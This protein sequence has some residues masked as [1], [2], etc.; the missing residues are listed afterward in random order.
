M[1]VGMPSHLCSSSYGDNVPV[2]ATGRFVAVVTMLSGIIILALPITVIGTNFAR[3]LRKMQRD[4]MLSDLENLDHN[5][6]GVIDMSELEV[7]L[8]M[9]V[10][11]S[12]GWV[13]T[14]LR[15]CALVTVAPETA[16]SVGTDGRYGQLDPR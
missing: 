15:W 16:C 1:M 11:G 6:D 2:T 10:V 13:L 5:D 8:G 7:R 12:V 3:V 14:W 9:M 4:K